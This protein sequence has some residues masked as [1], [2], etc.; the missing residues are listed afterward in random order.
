MNTTTPPDPASSPTTT[1]TLTTRSTR[2]STGNSRSITSIIQDVDRSFEGKTP[3]IGGIMALK[4]DKVTKKVPFETF[5]EVLV[6][7][8]TKELDRPRDVIAIVKDMIDPKPIFMK[9]YAIEDLSTEEEKSTT[10]KAMHMKQINL[11]VE[12]FDKIDE[13]IDKIFSYIWGQCTSGLQS[14]IVEMDDYEDKASECDVIWLLEQLKLATSGIDNTTN[15]YDNLI[16]TILTLFTM[17]QGDTESNDSFLKRF[18]SNVQSFEL[19]GGEHL[20]HGEK[21]EGKLT[22]DKEKKEASERFKAVLFVKRA[23]M[24]RYG[25]LWRTL[26]MDL[27]GAVMNIQ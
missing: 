26:K 3:E 1:T 5:R 13:N 22:D 24:N 12:R 10:K 15:K 11:F 16:E 21:L 4:I 14:V 18:K 6:E 17:R 7:Y 20:F 8:L 25:V 23:D 9:R 2:N 19:A 27:T